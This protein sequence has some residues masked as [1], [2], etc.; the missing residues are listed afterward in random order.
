[1]YALPVITVRAGRTQLFQGLLV[2]LPIELT[3]SAQLNF[4]ANM[5]KKGWGTCPQGYYVYVDDSS[6][7][8]RFVMP[9]LMI[10]GLKNSKKNFHI[11]K[12]T[13]TKEAIQAYAKSITDQADTIEKQKNSEISLLIHDLRALSSAIYNSA[14]E[15]R[16]AA[17]NGDFS[18]C[19]TRVETVIATHTMLS[20][21]IDML[22]VSTNQIT[23]A[24][25]DLIPVFKK[26]D[27]VVRC[28]RPKASARNISL[29]LRSLTGFSNSKIYGPAIFELVAYSIIDNAVKYSA[30]GKSIFVEIEDQDRDV[31]I[32]IKSMGPMIAPDERRKIFNRGYR[33]AF[34]V[35]SGQAGTGIGLS[36]AQELVENYFDGVI[37]AHQ[38]NVAQLING[39]SYFETTFEIV[40]PRDG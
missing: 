3:S 2:Q 35:S 23:L 30:D 5:T 16:S 10:E 4:Y 40:V 29:S 37:T 7:G 32:R 31:I 20:I 17:I 33:G 8:T 6:D 39:F 28:F 1:M 19:N 9:G 18:T 38:D 34:A 12:V 24:T 14:E 11:Q 25:A 22:D 21:R 27:K 15:A 13:H 36:L 26:L